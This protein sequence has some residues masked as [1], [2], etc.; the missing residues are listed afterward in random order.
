[1]RLMYNLGHSE[2]LCV[3]TSKKDIQAQIVVLTPTVF[4][5]ELQDKS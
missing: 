3:F 5:L 4:T 2:L 1:M